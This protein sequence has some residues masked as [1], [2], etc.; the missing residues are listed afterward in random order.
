MNNQLIPASVLAAADKVLFITDGTNAEFVY[1]QTYLKAFAQQYPH[2]EIH[3][4][5]RPKNSAWSLWPWRATKKNRLLDWLAAMPFIRKI[6]EESTHACKELYPLVIC[7]TQTR[8]AI[9]MRLARSV[10]KKGFVAAL[11]GKM[12]WYAV[13]AKLAA[14][15][16]DA[17]LAL[18]G[19]LL[20]VHIADQYAYWFERLVGLIVPQEKRFPS[21]LIPPAWTLYAKLLFLK[22]GID[23]QSKHFSRVIFINPFANNR[24]R[25][26][27][28][29]AVLAVVTALRRK[30]EFGDVSV[31]IHV[32]P[33]QE[34]Q[35]R[36]Y[37]NKNSLNNTFL[38]LAEINF[39]Q[40]PAVL[41]LCDFAISVDA[42]VMHFATA[43]RVP[44]VALV[45]R[46]NPVWGPL[47]T[48]NALVLTPQSRRGSVAGI[49]AAE[50][51]N[52]LEALKTQQPETIAP[53]V[54]KRNQSVA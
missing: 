43:L 12:P 30:D 19:S 10:N 17:L 2:C 29:D 5:L 7:L 34:K 3:L 51:L 50:V 53:V 22:W 23:K 38:L 54:A 6:Y 31:V 32:L 44:L 45:R 33:S 11:Q 15:R 14:S 35:V 21:L 46:K 16:C 18:N 25:S 37:F 41:S 36:A 24:K 13:R 49:S 20:Q 26:W 28:L 1:L 4:L 27:S 8:I 42:A 40:L 52:A 48:A 47:A 39:F 9:N